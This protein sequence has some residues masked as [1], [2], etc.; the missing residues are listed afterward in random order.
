M[1][2]TI[3]I[4]EF[5]I[6]AL[7]LSNSCIAMEL[8]KTILLDDGR[9]LGYASFGDPMG[10]PVMYFH[11]GQESRLSAIFMDSTAITL[12]IWIL[13]PDR[14]GI[15]LS[16][17]QEGRNF[18][19]WYS[20]IASL[21]TRLNIEKYSIFG[22]SGGAPHVLSCL[23]KNS[24]QISKAA[25][26][27][28]ATPYDYK[29]STRGMWLPV[30]LIHWFASWQ[31]D[32]MLRK[33]IQKDYEGLRNTP[34]KRVK[35]FQEHLPEPDQKLLR[36]HPEYAYEFIQ[37]SLE[38]YRQGI[39]GVVQE[40]RLYVADWEMEFSNIH[41]PVTLW[42][43]T[44][45]KMAPKYRGL[46]YERALPNSTLHLLEDEGHFSLVR[47]HLNAILQDLTE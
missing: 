44:D 1:N 15:G 26:V 3:R 10:F 29:G 25:I 9:T 47:N 7:C 33:I 11:G 17:F 30:K 19:D 46:F 31:G 16:T 24:M 23:L 32:K 36:E 28:G 5:W 8:N 6:I 2:F 40:W 37:G 39:E 35:Q 20:D 4:I 42:Y 34:D 22:L 38:S 18:S 43:G 21:A 13:A 45:D 12:G 27:S 14:P 41:I